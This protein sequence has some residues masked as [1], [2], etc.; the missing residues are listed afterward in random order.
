[1]DGHLHR[2]IRIARASSGARAAW[3]RISNRN[4]ERGPWQRTV[5]DVDRGVATS[6][7]SGTQLPDERLQ[8]M[9]SG[10]DAIAVRQRSSGA[11]LQILSSGEGGRVGG[12]AV[13]SRIGIPA[14]H[15]D[16]KCSHPHEDDE[17]E[18]NKRNDLP[19]F[20]VL[21][22]WAYSKS[23]QTIHCWVT[24]SMRNC[25]D[26]DRFPLPGNMGKKIGIWVEIETV[27]NDVC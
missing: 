26:V 7:P 24:G 16:G 10:V 6:V 2:V 1:M 14:A 19:P 11:G 12:A 21:A 22:G 18:H 9:R 5:D 17:H 3:R 25:V 20:T 27:T 15:V 4:L 13:P 8:R 23:R